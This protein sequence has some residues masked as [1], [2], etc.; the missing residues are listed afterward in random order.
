MGNNTST[1]ANQESAEEKDEAKEEKKTSKVMGDPR[2]VEVSVGET[3]EL[4]DRT[5]VVNEVEPNYFPPTRFIRVQSG[6]ELV[7]VY[8]TLQ[9][10]GSQQF[11]YNSL[12]FEV[13]DSNGVQRQRYSVSELP[14]PIEP[15]DLAPGGTLE[16][17]LVFKVPEGDRGLSLVYESFEE[18]TVETVTACL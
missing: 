16:G 10:T 15:G 4:R 11:S 12:N 6:Y 3:A 17:N 8:P 18:R 14:Y 2:A 13:Q 5:L 1:T 9:N 7:R